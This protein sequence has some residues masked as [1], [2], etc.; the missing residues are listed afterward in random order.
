M[1]GRGRGWV[2]DV[3]MCLQGAAKFGHCKQI[4]DPP[5]ITLSQGRPVLFSQ[6]TSPAFF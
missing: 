1:D 5:I 2:S 6:R 4:I 3:E